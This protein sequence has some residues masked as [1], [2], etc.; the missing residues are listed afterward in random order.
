MEKYQKLP[1]KNIHRNKS[2]GKLIPDNYIISR[3]HSLYRCN[4]R[5]DLQ[6]KE[7][8]EISHKTDI[9]DQT[10]RTINIE[11]TIQDQTQ[12]GVTTQIITEIVQTQTQKQIM[13]KRPF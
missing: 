7:I 1:N 6:I 2:S 8:H 9:V 11:T 5:E 13:F 10:V 3:Q 12:T 4:Y